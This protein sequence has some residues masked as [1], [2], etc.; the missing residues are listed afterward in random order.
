M[1]E[2]KQ[3]TKFS[4]SPRE[5]RPGFANMGAYLLDTMHFSDQSVEIFSLEQEFFP[6]LATKGELVAHI[7][8]GREDF[9]DIGTID[10]FD[11]INLNDEFIVW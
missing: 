10:A 1:I 3:I 4:H 11:K 6:D 9:Y 2:G 8:S 7:V 5:N